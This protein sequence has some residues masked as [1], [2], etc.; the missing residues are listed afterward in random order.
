MQDREAGAAD[1]KH[2]LSFGVRTR[3]PEGPSRSAAEG[4]T[5]ARVSGGA[6]RA[7]LTTGWGVVQGVVPPLLP[8]AEGTAKELELPKQNSRSAKTWSGPRL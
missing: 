4:S 5:L 2:A 1:D 7:E 8:G 6:R 3:C